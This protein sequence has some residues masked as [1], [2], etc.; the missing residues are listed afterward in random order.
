MIFIGGFFDYDIVIFMIRTSEEFIEK[1]DPI[2]Q[3]SNK[4]VLE[5]GCGKGHYTKQLARVAGV[6]H[7]N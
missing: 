5:I 3:F 4:A 7:G 1:T 2:V 6:Y